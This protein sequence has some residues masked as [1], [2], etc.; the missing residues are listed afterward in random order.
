MTNRIRIEGN[1]NRKKSKQ[2][3]E[4]RGQAGDDKRK[5]IKGE[6]DKAASGNKNI[7]NVKKTGGQRSS[8]E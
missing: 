7:R 1:K 8:R 4:D 2:E 3:Q 6:Q 5:M